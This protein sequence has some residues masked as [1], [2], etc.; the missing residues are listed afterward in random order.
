MKIYPKGKIS[1]GEHGFE[2]FADSIYWKT[3]MASGAKK[4][5]ERKLIAQANI[6]IEAGKYSSLKEQLQQKSQIKWMP[7]WGLL[8][9]LLGIALIWGWCRFRKM[10]S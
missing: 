1:F 5:Q 8:L 2:G 9:L 6:D 10:K 4:W 3:S 7:A